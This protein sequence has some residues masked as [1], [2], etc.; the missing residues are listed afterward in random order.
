MSTTEQQ[1]H[2]NDYFASKHGPFKERSNDTTSASQKAIDCQMN[3]C[4]SLTPNGDVHDISLDSI[5]EDEAFKVRANIEQETIDE[6]TQR[7]LEYK[8]SIDDADGAPYPF[9]P[10]CVWKREEGFV[11]I[12]GTL[13]FW[14]AVEAMM[15]TIRVAIFEGTED[16]ALLFAIKDNA[17]HGKRYSR[18][19]L[20]FCIKKVLFRF[21]DKT[22]SQLMEITGASRGH[23]ST[24]RTEFQQEQV[25]SSE[26]PTGETGQEKAKNSS[27]S[28]TKKK[29][30]VV[31][32]SRLEHF[33]SYLTLYPAC[34]K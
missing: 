22:I 4:S 11:L 29:L 19:D 15:S 33:K 5:V 6:Y 32:W 30:P 12:A 10:I 21:P 1:E 27:K 3:C 14:A 9:D 23:C 28:K 8:E 34:R 24:I 17:R 25:F 18:G 7:F 13:R 16:E 2:L 20:A 26:H 31:Y